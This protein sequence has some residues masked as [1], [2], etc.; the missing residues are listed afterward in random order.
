VADDAAYAVETT[1]LVEVDAAVRVE[2]R[3]AALD[4]R[5]R[6]LEQGPLAALRETLAARHDGRQQP[7]RL[8]RR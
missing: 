2:E 7:H 8:A 1:L 5:L 4:R 3:V 6:T